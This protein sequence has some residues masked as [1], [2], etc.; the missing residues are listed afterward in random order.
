[1]KPNQTNPLI[2]FILMMS[3]SLLAQPRI[4]AVTTNAPSVG[5]YQKWELTTTINNTNFTNPFD[6]AQAVLSCKFTA[7]SGTTKTVDGFWK[8]GQ[9]ITDLPK[10]IIIP[11]VSEDGWYVR[12]SP[13]EVGTWTYS[14]T[15]KDNGGTSTAST[16]SFTC[17]ASSKNGFVRR[18]IGKNYFKFDDGAPYIPIGQNIGWYNANGIGDLKTWVDAMSLNN[19]NYLRFWM[20]YWATELE[21]TPAAQ[22]S[23]YAGLKQYEQQ[24]AFELD[25]LVDYALENDMYIDLCLQ[26]QGQLQSPN[27]ATNYTPQW[28]TNPYN[29]ALGGSCTNPS[30]FWTNTTAKNT[31]KNKLRYILAR[32]GYSPNI[33]SWELFNDMDLTENYTSNTTNATNWAKE[34]AAYLKTT[35]PNGHLTTNSYYSASVDSALLKAADIDY[36]QVHYFD[37]INLSTPPIHGNFQNT[38]AD[39]AQAITTATSK[40]FMTGAFG[41]FQRDE[42]G[43]SRSYDPNGVMLHNMMW[44]SLLNGSAGAAAA[45]FWDTY[46]HPL[47]NTGYKNFKQLTDFANTQLDVVNKKY[48]P[49]KPVYT[50]PGIY[51]KVDIVPQ[52]AGFQPPAYNAARA[53]INNFSFNANGALSPAAT[54]LSSILFGN[55]H[56]SER[57][58]PTFNVNYPTAGQF[59]VKVTDR[60]FTNTSTLVIRV[61]GVAV[62]TQNNPDNASYSVNISP[63]TH[64]IT[65]DNTGNEWIQIGNIELINYDFSVPLTGNALQDG[66]HVVGWIL[67]RNYNWQYIR[68]N[69]GNLPPSVSNANIEITSLSQNALFIVKFFNTETNALINTL[70]LSSNNAGVLTIAIP[71]LA[72]DIAYRIESNIPVPL[73]LFS[74][75]GE[76]KPHNDILLKWTTATEKNVSLFDVQRSINNI[77]FTTI[78]TVRAIGNSQMKQNYQFE[79]KDATDGINYYRLQV[80]DLDN[81]ISYSPT[82]AIL[83]TGIQTPQSDPSVSSLTVFPNPTKDNIQ[84]DFDMKKNA[85][86][87]IQLMDISGKI[88]ERFSRSFTEGK[89]SLPIS[90][91]NLSKGIYF[92]K[93][94]SDEG[95]GVVKKIVKL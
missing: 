39:Q 83:L 85:L 13:T 10:G 8:K 22:N 6:F 61:D 57:N 40:P 95:R 9:E 43:N 65:I 60:D 14:L 36:N 38:L 46:T 30:D 24:H 59:K 88:V 35:D 62:L 19:A 74:F 37:G 90:I 23:P 3:I 21:W 41:L 26:N 93:M 81:R 64:T 31:Y 50:G 25:W 68:N 44:S 5:K 48:T 91:G 32:W 33:M 53:P 55:F 27:I 84:V 72:W 17:T 76:A 51:N 75:T 29:A 18:Q 52:F 28:Q 56:P 34:M 7:P 47:S 82:I 94:N 87:H 77:N 67:N 54:Y 73:D 58:P 11:K 15:F 20:C 12:F 16:G 89:Q 70:N 66:N 80:S 45:W 71:S 78:G 69:G 63:G 42:I 86:I 1:M 2:G 92:L 79:D 4:N 49:I